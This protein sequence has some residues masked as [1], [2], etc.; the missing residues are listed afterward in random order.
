MPLDEF[1]ADDEKTTIIVLLRWNIV[2]CTC[3]NDVDDD[4]D[5]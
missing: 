1:P 2:Y 4:Y 5:D 3:F